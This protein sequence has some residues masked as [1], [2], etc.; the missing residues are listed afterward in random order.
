MKFRLKPLARLEAFDWL[1][2]FCIVT[3][4]VRIVLHA[5]TAL[6]WW[7][8]GLCAFSFIGRRFIR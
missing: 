6:T 1:M 5:S 8:L 3:N 7:G 4:V 2:L